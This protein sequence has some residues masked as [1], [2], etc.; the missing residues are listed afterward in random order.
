[1]TIAPQRVAPLRVIVNAIPMINV[2][3]GIGRYIRSTYQEL[4]RLHGERLRVG[5]FDGRTAR[6][7]IPPLREDVAQ[8]TRKVD[9][10]WKLPPVLGFCVRLALFAARERTFMR[11]ARDYDLYHETAF[12]PFKA[13]KGLPLV[14]T[15]H[16]LS[17]LLHPQWHPKER[18]YFHR[19]FFRRRLRSV[20]SF[21]S[22]S[23]FTKGEME[24][25]LPLQGRCVT[26]TP[27][28]HEAKVFRPR[29]EAE[30]SALRARLGLPERFFLF[31][32]S[33]DPRKNA[34]LIRRAL[35]LCP[36]ETT[37]VLAGWS[38]WDEAPGGHAGGGRILPL[39]Y[40]TDEDLAGLYSAA[41]AL[42]L[43]SVYE[44]FGLPLLEAMACGCPVL[45]ARRASLP[46]VAGGAAL[47][48]DDPGDETELAAKLQQLNN[49]PA[50]RET[51]RRKGLERAAGFSW[52]RTA[53]GTLETFQ[54]AVRP[55]T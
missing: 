30:T 55:R 45:A 15:V 32:G 50:L 14:F 36:P 22:V 42:V 34:G 28:A 8:W 31:V 27:L 7:E 54:E 6:R 26:V 3:T 53:Q 46:E 33:G 21:L 5:Y 2:S 11:L 16:D 9:L 49:D 25:H 19:C 37:C 35:P 10:L 43:P 4:E 44:G 18:V 12:F 39:G 24:Q 40:V 52:T 48:L 29:S 47:Y 23:E 1:M 38:G 41:T 20:T 17:L 13:P 51:L